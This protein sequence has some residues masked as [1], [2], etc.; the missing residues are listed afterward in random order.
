M[1][2]STSITGPT[3]TCRSVSSNTSRATA[4]SSD[5]PT[6]TAPPGRLH[7]PLSGSRPRFTSSTRS[8]SNTTAPTPIMGLSGYRR[9]SSDITGLRWLYSHHLDH[10]ALFP[11]A[12][13]LSVEHLLPRPEVQLAGGNG[14]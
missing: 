4:V 9:G 10:H 13:E 12:I 14:Q 1:R 3:S 6:S 11:L 2:S 8:L 7:S 5:S